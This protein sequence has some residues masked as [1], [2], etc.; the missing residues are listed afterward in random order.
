VA[1]RA[2]ASTGWFLR[3]AAIGIAVLALAIAGGA[4]LMHSAIDPEA[5]GPAVEARNDA[6]AGVASW[7]FRDVGQTAEVGAGDDLVVVPATRDRQLLSRADVQALRHRTGGGDRVVLA[8]VSLA[9]IADSSDMWRSDWVVDVSPGDS[10]RSGVTFPRVPA[11]GAPAWLARENAVRRTTF[12]VRFWQSDWQA[13]L[14]G[15]SFSLINRLVAIGVDGI[16]LTGGD[17]AQS[18]SLERPGARDDLAAL[19]RRI[20]SHVRQLKPELLIVLENGDELVDDRRI[21]LAVDAFAITELFYSGSG[22]GE[23]IADEAIDARLARLRPLQ[24]DARPILVREQLLDA[25]SVAAVSA[26][27]RRLG[28]VPAV[29]ARSTGVRP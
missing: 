25:R 4:W 12:P 21:R 17:A 11:A 5:E 16:Y 6:L 27:V 20:A 23:P 9:E 19:V 22:A 1:P 14:I 18:W 26:R 2:P 8:H 10:S 29:E 7:A 28:L 13:R 15:R 24:I 3:R